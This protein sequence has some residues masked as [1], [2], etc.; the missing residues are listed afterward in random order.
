M[1]RNGKHT[2]KVTKLKREAVASGSKPQQPHGEGK[3]VTCTKV[4]KLG[5]GKG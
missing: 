2:D 5:K 3:G 1:S 4:I